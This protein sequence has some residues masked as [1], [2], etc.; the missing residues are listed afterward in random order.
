MNAQE[1]I[2]EAA[3][4]GLQLT[5]QGGN[6]TI[7]GSGS[8]PAPIIEEMRQHKAEIIGVL[9]GMKASSNEESE[10]SEESHSSRTG[11]L[12][13]VLP[14]VDTL[15]PLGPEERAHAIGQVMEQGR[16]AIGWCLA[17]AN[18]Y[19]EKFPGS[20][21]Q[22]QDAAAARDLLRWQGVNPDLPT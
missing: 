1:I 16:S 4:A 10:R 6:L 2:A 3:A 13:V 20:S 5:V 14:L 9:Q 22:E 21:F 8:R 18:D 17:R 7:Q 11:L 15:E 19:Y 12:P